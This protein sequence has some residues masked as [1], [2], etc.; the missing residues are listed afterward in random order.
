[1]L[2]KLMLV[3]M[4]ILMVVMCIST[5]T[6]AHIS[7]DTVKVSDVFEAT[8]GSLQY[9]IKV[10]ADGSFVT[11]TID[12]NTTKAKILASRSSCN[13]SVLITYGK[14][15][16]EKKAVNSKT[17]C[18]KTRKWKAAKCSQCKKNGFRV[19]TSDWKSYEHNYGFLGLRDTCK[20]CGRE[21]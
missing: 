3:T 16:T 21:K 13:H 11:Q 15:K 6:N 4:S 12:E 2:K 18:Y 14:Q 20:E 8:D 19:Y 7:I 10:N 9:V 17:V 1:M 5:S